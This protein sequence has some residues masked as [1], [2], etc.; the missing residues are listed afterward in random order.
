MRKQRKCSKRHSLTIFYYW[1]P[2]QRF[3]TKLHWKNCNIL[4][5]QM[6]PLYGRHKSQGFHILCYR[7]MN[8]TALRHYYFTLKSRICNCSN[9]RC[10]RRCVPVYSIPVFQI[11]TAVSKNVVSPPI[12]REANTIIWLFCVEFCKRFVHVYKS[13]M[14]PDHIWVPTKI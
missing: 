4:L 5:K 6:L 13:Q 2:N 11:L 12:V 10:T 1:I 3:F 14:D 9:N 8:L 7:C